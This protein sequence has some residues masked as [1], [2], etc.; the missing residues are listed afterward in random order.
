MV[1]LDW[2]PLPGGVA[3]PTYLVATDVQTR[4]S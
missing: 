1:G 4:T 2:I 3:V